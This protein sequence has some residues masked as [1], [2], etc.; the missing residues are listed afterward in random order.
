MPMKKEKLFNLIEN[1]PTAFNCVHYLKNILKEQNFQEV[2]EQENWDLKDSL[3]FTT[4]ND[5]SLIDFKIPANPDH[6]Q[7]IT[8]H[9]DTPSL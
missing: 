4:R 3:Y 8:T 9:C 2:V 7:I 5:A 1:S 6:F